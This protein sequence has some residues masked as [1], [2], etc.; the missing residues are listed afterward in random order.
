MKT[1]LA[2]TLS[3]LCLAAALV[4]VAPACA[5]LDDGPEATFEDL[6]RNYDEMYGCFELREVDWDAA[7][8]TYRPQVDATTSEDE[9]FEI[10]TQMLAETDDGHIHLTVPGRVRWSANQIYR[11]SIGFERF[12]RE[13]VKDVYLGGEYRADPLEDYILGEL[14]GG[15]TYVHLAWISDQTPIL[16]KVREEAEAASGGLIIDL[17]H[18]GGGDFTWAFDTLAEWTASDRPVYRSRTRNGPGRDAFTPWFEWSVEGRGTDIEFP[19]VVLIDRFTISAGERAVLALDVLDNV[20]FVGE[21]TS[22]ALSTTVGRE[23][24][25]GWYMTVSTQEIVGLDGDS[26]EGLGFAPDELVINEPA[27]MDAGV[28]QVLE[29]AIE[30]LG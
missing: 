20:T 1:P 26:L 24:V 13:L 7:Y 14:E 29:R 9:L 11:E 10:I 19:V 15:I 27:M 4:G 18:N 5:E 16:A 22:G 12:D 25:N 8:A 6:W 21:P 30:L 23:L 2:S 3:R 28:D 17:R